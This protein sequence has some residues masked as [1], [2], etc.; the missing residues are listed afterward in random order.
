VR[1]LK[2]GDE[3]LRGK[4]ERETP[5]SRDSQTGKKDELTEEKD[6]RVERRQKL[7]KQP[8]YNQFSFVSTLT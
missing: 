3:C 7:Y 8:S 5:E 2:V 4:K 6:L 1:E